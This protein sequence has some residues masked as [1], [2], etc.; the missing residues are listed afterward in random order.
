MRRERSVLGR[1][2]SLLLQ[3]SFITEG[4]GGLS[5]LIYTKKLQASKSNLDRLRKLQ[6]SQYMFVMSC[7]SDSSVMW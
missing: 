6:K 7:L 4:S 3:R 5:I 1:D 2:V